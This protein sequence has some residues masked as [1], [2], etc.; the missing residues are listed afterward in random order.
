MLVFKEDEQ[1]PICKMT[2]EDFF[3]IKAIFYEVQQYAWFADYSRRDSGKTLNL[4]DLKN[5]KQGVK[6]V[7]N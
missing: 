2:L 1:M 5:A 7:E 4:G 6:S 3:R